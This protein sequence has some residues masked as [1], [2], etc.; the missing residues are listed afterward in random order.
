MDWETY[1]RAHEML[2][3]RPEVHDA[4]FRRAASHEELS[5]AARIVLLSAVSRPAPEDRELLFAIWRRAIDAGR[6]ATI[7]VHVGHGR[8]TVFVPY[9]TDACAVAYAFA[10]LGD[11]DALGRLWEECPA[12]DGVLRAE[13]AFSC[14]LS[15]KRELLEPVLDYVR[16]D[17]NRMAAAGGYVDLIPQ[18]PK[19]GTRSMRNSG[20]LDLMYRSREITRFVAHD[21]ADP[22]LL[23][24]LIEDDALHPYLRL[25]WISNLPYHL[26]DDAPMRAAGEAALDRIEAAQADASATMKEMIRSARRVFR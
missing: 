18:N 10:R 2:E 19:P 22:A 25:F 24:R 7:E 23:R 14:A 4:V 11:A 5:D 1:G 16:R 12:G 21:N 3:R 9:N 13:I 15:R 6:R 8:Q 17:W 26:R 20:A